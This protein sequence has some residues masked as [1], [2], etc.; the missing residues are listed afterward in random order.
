MTTPSPSPANESQ[1]LFV[2]VPL[3][4]TLKLRISAWTN[5][6]R[7]SLP[8]RKWTNE[9]DLHVTLHF[10]GDTSATRIPELEAALVSEVGSGRIQPFHLSLAGTGTFGNPE[11]PRVLWAGLGGELDQLR[12][13]QHLIVD[14]MT[15]LGFPAEDRAYSPHLTLARKYT[16]KE[17]FILPELLLADNSSGQMDYGSPPNTDEQLQR[18]A[19]DMDNPPGWLVDEIIL[20]RTHMHRVPMYEKAAHI[21][22]R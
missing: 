20:Y 16:G 11:Q 22:L 19:Y 10:L 4:D 3:P 15:P 8:F 2:A 7:S 17:A 12:A 6:V 21:S 14:T 9:A 13:L 5:D 18:E 1:R